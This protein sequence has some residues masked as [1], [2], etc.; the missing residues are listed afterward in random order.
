MDESFEREKRENISRL[1]EDHSLQALALQFMRLTGSYQYTYNFCWM[2]LPIIQ[3]PQDI[4]AMQE[5]I[6]KVR[7]DLIV[8]TGIARGGS[9]VFYASLLELLDSNGHVLGIDIDIRAHNRAAIQSH[10]MS[11]RISMIEGSSV[12]E[13]VAAQVSQMASGFKS[14]LVVLDSN[15]THEHVLRELEL[16]APLVKC[17][18]YI[19]VFDTSI[20]D[21]PA[22]HH[23]G[24]PWD[25]GNNPKTAVR[26]FLTQC[27]RFVVDDEIDSKLLVTVARDGFLKCV[28]N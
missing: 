27:D 11:K 4:M 7:P 25:K 3:F 12:D 5:I 9:L 28:K 6:W 19:V 18:S 20:E 10:S 16:Y 17:G 15:H 13:E 1:G 14:V 22:G 8:E 21:Q 24:R 26:E 2:G 23:A